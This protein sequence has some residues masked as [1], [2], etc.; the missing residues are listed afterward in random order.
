MFKVIGGGK[1][2]LSL[3]VDVPLDSQIL[4]VIRIFNSTRRIKVLYT[5]CHF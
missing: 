3:V 2:S 1:E 5:L 4:I